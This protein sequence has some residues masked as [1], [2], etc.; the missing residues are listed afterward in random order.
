MSGGKK[1]GMVMFE[2]GPNG[3]LIDKSPDALRRQH[4]NQIKKQPVAE[5]KLEPLSEDDLDER[6]QVS[7]RA[8]QKNRPI[9]N[10]NTQLLD[11][12]NAQIVDMNNA[13]PGLKQVLKRAET[14]EAKTMIMEAP[15]VDP[16][17]VK[18][19]AKNQ[20]YASPA[21]KTMMADRSSDQTL[22]MDAQYMRQQTDAAFGRS[23]DTAFI[24][25]NK[26]EKSA[27]NP[28]TVKKPSRLKQFLPRWLGGS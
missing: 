16:L 25:L 19:V 12:R 17:D 27:G 20:R 2:I 3:S 22:M 23:G 24:D 5:E 21:D 15:P 8:W 18:V 26:A 11:A 6:T 13:D 7:F 1:D 10:D 4:E 28:Q 9:H 14:A